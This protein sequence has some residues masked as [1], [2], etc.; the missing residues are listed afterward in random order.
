MPENEKTEMEVIAEFTK[1][2]G[3]GLIKAKKLYETGYKTMDDLKKA[4][5]EELA[6]IDGI[7]E[8]RATLIKNYFIELAEKERKEASVEPAETKE[9]ATESGENV[10]AAG[11]TEE[12]TEKPEEDKEEIAT[13]ESQIEEMKE[14]VV[15]S[16]ETRVEPPVNGNG[17]R[18]NGLIN[19]ISPKKNY[20]PRK[21]K[22]DT[23][24]K[25]VAVGLISVLVLAS[26]ITI[27]YAFLPESPI[28]VDGRIDD[29][30]GIATYRENPSGSMGNIDIV[31]YG[32]LF[33]EKRVNFFARTQG[34]IFSTSNGVDAFRIFIDADSAANTGYQYKGLGAEYKIEVSGWDGVIHTANLQKFNTEANPMNYSAWEN[35]GEVRVE[36]GTNIVEGYIKMSGLSNSRAVFVMTHYE[37]GNLAEKVCGA[38]ATPKHGSLSV[39]QRYIGGD[40]VNAGDEVL[41]IKLVARGGDVCVNSIAVENADV[42]LPK[43]VLA[44]DEEIVVRATSKSLS[45]GQG[46]QF[47]ITQIGTEAPYLIA[48]S[49]GTAYFG[50]LPAGIVIEGAFGDWAGRT[51]GVDVKGDGKPDTDIVEYAAALS[52]NAYFY[53]AVD[54]SMLAG[55]EIPLLSARPSPQ[56]GPV[57]PVVLKEN[58]GLDIARVYID[59]MNSTINTFNP[60]MISHG[61]MIELQG[62]NG[63]VISARAWNWENG[64]RAG[65]ITNANVIYGI[66]NGK[67]E[68]SADMTALPGITSDSK[69]YFEMTNW[70]G[71]KDVSEIAYTRDMGE[72]RMRHTDI[73]QGSITMKKFYP[74]QARQP[75]WIYGNI[76]PAGTY[77]IRL[78]N[79]NTNEMVTTMSDSSGYFGTSLFNPGAEPGDTI[80]IEVFSDPGYTNQ[81][82]VNPAQ[83]VVTPGDM[84]NPYIGGP[85]K[86]MSTTV[87]E[88]Q[89]IFLSVVLL[90]AGLCTAGLRRRKN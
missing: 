16:K 4:S 32:M 56:P 41:E 42:S 10:E 9:T 65:E 86:D 82:T 23:V 83:K 21:R 81:L 5:F 33:E 69:F 12:K 35:A 90:G 37:G 14:L 72:I 48:G 64:M 51:K 28:S 68:F 20:Q 31:E 75:M 6:K 87:P 44:K 84:S 73:V 45:A 71:E 66:S 79:L 15:K 61:Y 36:K 62:R 52:N 43:T 7:G 27:W 85:A 60:A 59:L 74:L 77:Y 55:C 2:P 80:R 13:M 38:P 49:G 57:G 50:S 40:V 39:S 54:G 34:E 58:L 29:W 47:K 63:Q 1:I 76:T 88:M 22:P 70:L 8:S 19:G 17:R 26:I 18:E 11:V 89:P 53:M 30:R 78:T 46:Y 25:Y 67:V 24:M 3:L